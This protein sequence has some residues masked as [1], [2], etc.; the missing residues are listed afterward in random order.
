MN[1]IIIAS[2]IYRLSKNEKLFMKT[3]EQKDVM[4][5]L[6]LILITA[7]ILKFLNCFLLIDTIILAI[8]FSLKK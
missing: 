6:K 1:F 5:I 7:S 3:E 8:D 2:F 4:N